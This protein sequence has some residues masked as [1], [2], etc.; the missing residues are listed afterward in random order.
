MDYLMARG[1]FTWLG[2]IH[3]FPDGILYPLAYWE[4]KAPGMIEVR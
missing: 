2:L 1:I 4:A 3:M